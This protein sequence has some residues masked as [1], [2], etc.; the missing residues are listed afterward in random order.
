MI[1]EDS[2]NVRIGDTR[3][4]VVFDRGAN[5]LSL[6]LPVNRRPGPL[7]LDV[8]FENMFKHSNTRPRI[9]LQVA[10]DGAETRP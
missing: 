2:V 5:R 3:W 4:P 8:Q 9:V 1:F 10:P 6:Y 7:V